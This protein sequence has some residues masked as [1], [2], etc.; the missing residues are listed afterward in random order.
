[1]DM[2]EREKEPLLVLIFSWL[3]FKVLKRLY[4]NSSEISGISWMDL[5]IWAAGDWRVAYTLTNLA[6]FYPFASA[7]PLV[8]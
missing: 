2:S 8:L 4:Q 7:S 5:Q 1:M 3:Y 6:D